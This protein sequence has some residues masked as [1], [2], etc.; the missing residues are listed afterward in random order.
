MLRKLWLLLWAVWLVALRN[1]N[2]S[3][4]FWVPTMLTLPLWFYGVKW[5]LTSAMA[6]ASLASSA[7]GFCS[8]Q[9]DDVLNAWHRK[10][11]K[12]RKAAA[13]TLG[14][15]AILGG[16]LCRRYTGSAKLL[17]IQREA[18]VVFSGVL[19]AAFGVSCLWF[20]LFAQTLIH[21]W[22]SLLVGYNFF[23][24]ASLV[25]T[26]IWALGC[27]TTAIGFPAGPSSVWV[28]VLHAFILATGIF[29]VTYLLACFSI[30]SATD[31]T[32]VSDRVTVPVTELEVKVSM[33]F[34]MREA[35]ETRMKTG[36]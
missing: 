18:I 32:R 4:V 5:S 28:K 36:A 21:T 11:D 31:A 26:T 15:W 9:L 30:I 10:N 16:I 6:P 25:E 23:T 12:E 20:G 1:V 2:A 27:M 34:G 7:V 35:F 22:P 14:L 8:R 29:Q 17:V 13:G 3:W 33:A 24:S 19:L